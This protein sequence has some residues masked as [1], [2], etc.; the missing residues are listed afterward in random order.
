MCCICCNLYPM[1]IFLPFLSCVYKGSENECWARY[2]LFCVYAC[3]FPH[4]QPPFRWH[5]YFQSLIVLIYS[6]NFGIYLTLTDISIHSLFSLW[7]SDFSPRGKI[8]LALLHTAVMEW[9]FM[10]FAWRLFPNAKLFLLWFCTERNY[11]HNCY[12]GC[13]IITWPGCQMLS[14]DCRIIK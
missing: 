8:C 11:E 13:H 3:P 12:G 7:M 14:F 2:L 4:P 5:M 6:I 1:C 9:P 10:L